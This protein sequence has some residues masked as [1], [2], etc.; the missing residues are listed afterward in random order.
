MNWIEYEMNR[1][2]MQGDGER[3]LARRL[4]AIDRAEA[5]PYS[6]GQDVK[7]DMMADAL[8]DA[9]IGPDRADQTAYRLASDLQTEYGYMTE[10]A[11][12][13]AGIMRQEGKSFEQKRSEID[14]LLGR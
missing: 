14:A 3:D 9:F 8:W 6:G 2:D 12:K 1:D 10:R 7:D 4:E 11:Q 13:I 5:V